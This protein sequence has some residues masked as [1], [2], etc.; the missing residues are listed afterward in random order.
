M[1]RPAVEESELLLGRVR[2]VARLIEDRERVAVGEHVLVTA[3]REGGGEHV[4]PIADAHAL[5][6]LEPRMRQRAVVMADRHPCERS[7]FRLLDAERPDQLLP[8]RA[9]AL[10][11]AV[12]QRHVQPAG[13]VDLAFKA[14]MQLHALLERQLALERGVGAN[15]RRKVLRINGFCHW[16]LLHAA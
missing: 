6:G 5:H 13:R 15:R 14:S 3:A 12:E 2:D 8:R 16:C 4:V 11:R 10:E 1:P 7:L 9:V